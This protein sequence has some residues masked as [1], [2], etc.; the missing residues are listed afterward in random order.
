[1]EPPPIWRDPTQVLVEAKR[2]PVDTSE[3]SDF[4]DTHQH[5]HAKGM[6]RKGGE[7][8]AER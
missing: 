2:K 7:S 8:P 6:S 5:P 4:K 3:W 1:M